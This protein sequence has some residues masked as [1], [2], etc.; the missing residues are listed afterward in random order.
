MIA[1]LSEP[2]RYA[3]TAMIAKCVSVMTFFPQN[4]FFRA[5]HGYS[6]SPRS[7]T[8][9]RTGVPVRPNTSRI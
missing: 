7:R 3:Q 6:L 4:S 8:T 1:K 2:S 9:M 5:A